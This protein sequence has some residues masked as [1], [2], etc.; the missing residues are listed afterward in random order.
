MEMKETSLQQLLVL[1][2]ASP[3]KPTSGWIGGYILW[4]DFLRL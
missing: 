4:A 1:S 2:V 3:T